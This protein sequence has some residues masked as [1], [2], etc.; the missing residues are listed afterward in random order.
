MEQPT[1]KIVPKSKTE[2]DPAA[3]PAID[4]VQLH[5]NISKAEEQ[6][7]Q[8]EQQK[9]VDDLGLDDINDEISPY[10][11]FELA[12][13]SSHPADKVQ[14][15]LEQDWLNKNLNADTKEFEG[16]KLNN[17]IVLGYVKDQT[18]FLNK[19]MREAGTL[20]H[21]AFHYTFRYLFNNSTRDKL[22]TE[23]QSDRKYDSHFTKKAIDKFHN[24]FDRINKNII[25]E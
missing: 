21:E 16:L 12:S 23:I 3:Q 4:D 19:Q 11:A 9:P 8:P 20:Y 18:I 25:Q 7:T 17:N 10:D 14:Q 1:V 5:E 2:V 13:R 22:V 24:H 15:E 6:I